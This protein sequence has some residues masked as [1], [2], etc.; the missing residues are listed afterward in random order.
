MNTGPITQTIEQAFGVIIA[1]L[2]KVVAAR[3]NARTNWGT[4]IEPLPGPLIIAL[5]TR[6]MRI[7]TRFQAVM[8]QIRAG[9]LRAPRVRRPE[10]A[11]RRTARKA[12]LAAMDPPPPPRPP[13]PGPGP[14]VPLPRDF[15]YVIRLVPW[16]AA[17]FANHMRILLAKPEMAELIGAT[18]R[19]QRLLRPLCHM[20]GIEITGLIP[21]PP[22]AGVGETRGTPQA[23]S[24]P[25]ARSAGEIPADIGPALELAIVVEARSA[26]PPMGC[27]LKPAHE[28]R[29]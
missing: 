13:P 8:A 20:L 27:S 23:P 6:L 5:W 24:P 14:M 19:L 4:P 10:E 9:T 2:C 28:G 21:P 3:S 17:P 15:G 29:A 11:A 1:A 22:P 25:L 7:N 12:E 18:P 16:H 26:G